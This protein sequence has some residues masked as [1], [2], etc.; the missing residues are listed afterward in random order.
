MSTQANRATYLESLAVARSKAGDTDAETE[1]QNLIRTEDQ[2]Y[3][4]RLIKQA[5]NV[6]HRGRL[7][8]V[9]LQLPDGSYTECTAKE[10]IEA[11]CLAEN[12]SQ[13][14][15]SNRTPS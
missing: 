5:H 12:D 14:S 10:D 7:R 11:A 15:Q 4:I 6:T 13:F 2:R 8:H 3:R 9:Q 1:L